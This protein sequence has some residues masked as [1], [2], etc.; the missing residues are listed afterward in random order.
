M[1]I[2]VQVEIELDPSIINPMYTITFPGGLQ[3]IY[4]DKV[5]SGLNFALLH[6][7]MESQAKQKGH[8]SAEY[9]LV[10][11]KKNGVNFIRSHEGNSLMCLI[12][13]TRTGEPENDNA[14]T[15]RVYHLLRLF[16][17]VPTENLAQKMD[18]RERL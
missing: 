15:E 2:Q 17:G 4:I 11:G 13:N 14:F 10:I 8:K 5:Q 18:I 7:F 3:H 1:K 6:S 9:E 12:W 16:T